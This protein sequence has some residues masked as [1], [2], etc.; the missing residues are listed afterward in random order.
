VVNVFLLAVS[1]QAQTP[2]SE[3]STLIETITKFE[4]VKGKYLLFGRFVCFNLD[5]LVYFMN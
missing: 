1:S 3:P 2:Q 5:G 4:N